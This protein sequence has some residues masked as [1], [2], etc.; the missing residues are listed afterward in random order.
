MACIYKREP[1]VSM[2]V[3]NQQA[4]YFKKATGLSSFTCKE[5]KQIREAVQRS[6]VSG[7]SQTITTRSVGHNEQGEIIAEFQ[8]IWSFKVRSNR[9][10]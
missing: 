2:L 9:P 7:E 1:P 5:G 3:I 4:D 8:V 10:R 6:I